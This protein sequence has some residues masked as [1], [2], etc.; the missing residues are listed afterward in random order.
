MS[1]WSNRLRSAL[2]KNDGWSLKLWRQP[3]IHIDDAESFAYEMLVRLVRPDGTVLTA[4]EFIDAICEER[5]LIR[6]LDWWVIMRTVSLISS[7]GIRHAVNIESATLGGENFPERVAQL[8]KEKQIDPSLLM[9]ELVERHPIDE[10]ESANLEKLFW[11][12]P[13]HLDD[14][15]AL[16]TRNSGIGYLADYRFAGIKLDRSLVKSVCENHRSATI[17]GSLLAMC[18]GL[19]ISCTCEGVEDD[20]TLQKLKSMY[21]TLRGRSA[22]EV[23]P[24]E[25]YVQGWE[26][27]RLVKGG[28]N[29]PQLL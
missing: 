17:V 28:K 13:V 27:D 10:D 23:Q 19:G 9:F 5:S 14:I 7:T 21:R 3:I 15:G 1:L 4:G 8:L 24:F 11:S 16:E 18:M 22:P 2:T 29:E 26:I 20:R 25:L 6:A 12:S